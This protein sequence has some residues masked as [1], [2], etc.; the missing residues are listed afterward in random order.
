MNKVS[1]APK[2]L[3]EKTILKPDPKPDDPSKKEISIFPLPN[4]VKLNFPKR[5]SNAS[6]MATSANIQNPVNVIKVPETRKDFRFDEPGKKRKEKELR[7]SELT[8]SYR[9]N[10]HFLKML[11]YQAQRKSTEWMRLSY[12]QKLIVADMI[13]ALAGITG[14]I[15]EV[16]SVSSYFTKA[17]KYY[18]NSA[19]RTL[20]G[21]GIKSEY[22]QI[23]PQVS[24]YFF[25]QASS[26]F[27]TLICLLCLFLSYHFEYYA[28]I[29]RNI[30][31]LKGTI[32]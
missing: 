13:G 28:L 9:E 18:E 4:K 31:G 10:R 8:E 14:V 16:I 22:L 5:N 20:V 25:M 17:R 23:N 3:T 27:C 24:S 19:V 21:K 26:S 1:V 32:K 12:T 7:L 29:Q 2:K 30:I 6:K 11:D 15:I